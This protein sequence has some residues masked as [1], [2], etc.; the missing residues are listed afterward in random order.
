M[1]KAIFPYILASFSKLNDF[2]IDF[3]SFRFHWFT[4]EYWI[5]LFYKFWPFYL[6][7]RAQNENAQPAE[8]FSFSLNFKGFYQT[9]ISY[10]IL[11]LET[12]IDTTKMFFCQNKTVSRILVLTSFDAWIQLFLSYFGNIFKTKRLQSQFHSKGSGSGRVFLQHFLEIPPI[13][14]FS[15]WLYDLKRK[16]RNR[17]IF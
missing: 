13:L 15:F 3:I 6:D 14:H 7:A 2:K 17:G 4:L 8:I 16:H 5:D 11:I 9:S 12:R 1:R 10:T